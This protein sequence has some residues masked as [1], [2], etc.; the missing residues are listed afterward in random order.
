MA[1]QFQKIAAGRPLIFTVIGFKAVERPFSSS[2]NPRQFNQRFVAVVEVWAGRETQ[3]LPESVTAPVAA[4]YH[5]RYF[6]D[7]FGPESFQGGI[8]KAGTYAAMTDFAC[9]TGVMD[10]PAPS[11]MTAHNHADDSA[12]VFSVR[13]KTS[14]WVSLQISGYALTTVIHIIQA[15]ARGSA[16]KSVD[17]VIVI[18]FEFTD[19]HCT[20]PSFSR[21]RFAGIRRAQICEARILG[22]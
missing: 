13:H 8:Y 16:P 20:S 17:G 7:A 18:N 22:Q 5:E 4:E 11:V 19:F 10:E 2:I 6:G 12:L 21:R 9:H 15:H 1:P 14:M 3:T